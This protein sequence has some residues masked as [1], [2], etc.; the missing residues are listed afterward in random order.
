MTHRYTVECQQ[1]GTTFEATGADVDYLDETPC[2]G[3]DRI[4][5]YEVE[6]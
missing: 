2:P 1:C 3:C 4:A 6:G 5:V